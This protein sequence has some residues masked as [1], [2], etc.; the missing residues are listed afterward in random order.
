MQNKLSLKSWDLTWQSSTK[1]AVQN[2]NLK[3]APLSKPNYSMAYQ[4]TQ[5]FLS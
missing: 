4:N 1:Q 5:S 3:Q 2:L